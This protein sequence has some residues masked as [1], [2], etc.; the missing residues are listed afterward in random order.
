MCLIKA[1]SVTYKTN[2]HDETAMLGKA[3]STF[4]I[5]QNRFGKPNPVEKTLV[6]DKIPMLTS[7]GIEG[8][9]LYEDGSAKPPG[10]L[11]PNFLKR[12]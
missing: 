2:F 8:M 4:N 12:F 9:F 3:P 5:L 11:R 1:T 7:I 10:Y 6:K